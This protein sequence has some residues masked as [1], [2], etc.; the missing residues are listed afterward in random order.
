[1][2][3]NGVVKEMETAIA[4]I[5]CIWKFNIQLHFLLDIYLKIQQLSVSIWIIRPLISKYAV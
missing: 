4:D 1:M 5:Y 2:D 3:P